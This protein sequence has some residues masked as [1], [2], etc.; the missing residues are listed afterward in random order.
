ME[1]KVRSHGP[2]QIKGSCDTPAQSLIGLIGYSYQQDA[3]SFP[4]AGL[5]RTPRLSVLG[6]EQFGDGWP[7]RK[8]FPGAHEW[9]QSVQKR[10]VLVCECSLCPRKLPDVVI[11][12]LKN[13]KSSTHHKPRITLVCRTTQKHKKYYSILWKNT[14]QN[15]DNT[16]L[17]CEKYYLSKK[18]ILL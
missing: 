5:Q 8:W 1:F 10:H 2:T 18:K 14:T 4:K 17:N 6:P 13:H 15:Y 7:T 12:V 11:L 16:Y 3:T 9:G